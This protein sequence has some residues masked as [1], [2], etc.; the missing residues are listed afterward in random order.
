MLSHL[1][2]S[3]SPPPKVSVVS[4]SKGESYIYND[5][6]VLRRPRN[7]IS[8]H[9]LLEMK[10]HGYDLTRPQEVPRHLKPSQVSGDLVGHGLSNYG[11]V[12]NESYSLYSYMKQLNINSLLYRYI[13]LY[14]T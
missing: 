6:Q 4:V 2:F 8:S 12:Y 13:L 10:G 1:F 9:R 5:I 11:M 14:N 7:Y 3:M